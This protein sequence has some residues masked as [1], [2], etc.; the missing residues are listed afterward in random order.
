MPNLNISMTGRSAGD[1]ISSTYEGRHLTV[2][3]SAITHPSHTDG[4]VDGGDPVLVGDM[5][6]GVALSSATAAT[7]YIAIDTEGIW[8]LTVQGVDGIGNVA[9]AEGDQVYINKTTCVLSKDNDKNTHQRFGIALSPVVSG[10]LTTVTA[11]KVHFDPDEAMEIVGD[12]GAYYVNDAASTTF[13]HYRYDCGATSGFS[14]GMYLRLAVTGAAAGGQAA[15][16]FTTVD[17]VSGSTARGA[18]ISLDFDATGSLT[19][20][21]AAMDATLHIPNA[22]MAANGEY[23]AISADINADGAA[24]DPAAVAQL[25]YIRA[26]LQ[27]D[28]TGQDAIDDVANF[29]AFTGQDV[30]ANNMIFTN[31]ALAATHLIRCSLNGVAFYLMATDTPA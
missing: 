8:A 5:I 30:G 24:S 25:S 11:V 9:V 2:L 10:V 3:E 23:A 29:I 15:R 20:L 21:G 17:D 28:G 22:A 19:G 12:S 4:L 13:R 31:A 6:V 1:E 18:H 14:Q 27:G 26:S 16:L 7:D